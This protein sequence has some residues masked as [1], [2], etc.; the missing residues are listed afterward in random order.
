VN[1]LCDD[2]TFESSISVDKETS[3]LKTEIPCQGKDRSDVPH[4][5]EAC[6]NCHLG[7][8]LFTISINIDLF[9]VVKTSGFVSAK[10]FFSL[11]DFQSSLFRPPIV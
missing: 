11:S 9:S 10:Y 6:H 7:H 8:C 5:H 3:I 4:R 1:A 2:S